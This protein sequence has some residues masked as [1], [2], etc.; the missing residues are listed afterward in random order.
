MSV[1]LLVQ[2]LYLSGLSSG[3][4]D[5]GSREKKN[6]ALQL[7]VELIMNGVLSH[8]IQWKILSTNYIIIEKSG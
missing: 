7:F 8:N 3:T 6:M 2:L 1:G 5:L 4:V